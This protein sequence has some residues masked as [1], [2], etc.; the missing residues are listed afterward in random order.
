MTKQEYYNS[1]N[2]DLKQ[3]MSQQDSAFRNKMIGSNISVRST[4]Q[5]DTKS[6]YQ[7]RPEIDEK[8]VQKAKHTE[9]ARLGQ[10]SG[11]DYHSVD[12][13]SV[14]VSNK[15]SQHDN[16]GM[17]HNIVM[18]RVNIDS[19]SHGRNVERHTASINA[20]SDSTEEYNQVISESRKKES[21]DVIKKRIEKQ[22]I[23]EF[24]QKDDWM[25]FSKFIIVHSYDDYINKVRN[26]IK[27][28]EITGVYL[29]AN[30]TKSKMYVGYG[31]KSIEKCGQ[32][33]RMRIGSKDPV[34]EIREDLLFDDTICVNFVK[35]K[36]TDFDTVK[37]LGDYYIRKYKCWRPRGY[38]DM[39]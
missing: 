26:Q 19:S 34:P 1:Q 24:L 2:N 25:F 27:L 18:E 14:I 16:Q 13:D 17:K 6:P 12:V 4:W 35:L 7:K 10:S 38:N 30:I 11:Q 22:R 29:I 37:E 33:F 31:S 3:R 5:K 32:H 15:K 28:T 9:L 36:D 8:A 39:P 21:E 20:S 23:K